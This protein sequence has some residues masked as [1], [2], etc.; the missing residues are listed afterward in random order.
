MQFGDPYYTPITAFGLQWVYRTVREGARDAAPMR[1]AGIALLV[2]E[3]YNVNE[4]HR[5]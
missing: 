4:T 2:L 3:A 5:K 1:L